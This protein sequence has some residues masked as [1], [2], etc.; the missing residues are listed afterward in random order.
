MSYFVHRFNTTLTFKGKEVE[1]KV[2]FRYYPGCPSSRTKNCPMGYPEKPAEA[3][4]I[5]ITAKDG[6]AYQFDALTE[7]QQETLD[8]LCHKA[9]GE[10]MNDLSL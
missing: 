8:E 7:K 4:V 1:V 10:L 5:S 6:T 2:A 3:E 9:A